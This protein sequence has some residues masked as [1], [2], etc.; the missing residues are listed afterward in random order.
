MHN[1]N[2][3]NKILSLYRQFL[4]ISNNTPYIRKKNIRLI[5]KLNKSLTNIDDI[6]KEY[7]NGIK[8]YNILEKEKEKKID[9]F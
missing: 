8:L 5:F 7:N 4:S 3:R 1:P 2:H 9:L 6:N